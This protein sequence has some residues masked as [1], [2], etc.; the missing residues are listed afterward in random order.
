MLVDT[1]P[2]VKDSYTDPLV[3]CS[4]QTELPIPDIV[5]PN[6]VFRLQFFDNSIFMLATLLDEFYQSTEDLISLELGKKKWEYL[7]VSDG[8]IGNINLDDRLY[9]AFP[10]QS[11]SLLV[12]F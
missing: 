4:F 12:P 7:R 5:L 6:F 11:L 10:P 1:D 2:V 3:C 8:L 9:T